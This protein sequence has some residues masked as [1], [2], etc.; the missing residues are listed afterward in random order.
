MNLGS[1]LKRL[2]C[3]LLA[4]FMVL[5]VVG[6]KE[7]KKKKIKKVIK[8]KVIVQNNDDDDNSNND[9][10]IEEDDDDDDDNVDTWVRPERDLPEVKAV[11]EKYVEP[12]IPEFDY[13]YKSLTLDNDYIVVYSLET[14]S[15]RFEGKNADGS[16]KEITTTANNRVAAKDLLV[17]LKDNY[18]V[19]LKIYSN[20]EYD[21]AVKDGSLTGNEKKIIFGD[22]AGYK[23]KLGENEFAVNVYGDNLVFEGGHFAMI[24]KA[25]KW[26]ESIKVEKDKV[27]TLY[28]KSE[29]FKSTVTLEN[30][31]TYTYVWGDEHDGNGIIDNDKW[32]QGA[33]KEGDDLVS[34]LNDPAFHELKNG[35]LRLTGNRY[36]DESNGDVGYAISGDTATSNSMLF[37]NGYV[38]FRARLPYARGAFPAIWS[39]STT[40]NIEKQVPNWE[41]NDGYGV[42]K[43]RAWNIEFDLFESFS[44][45][46]HMTTTVHKWYNG[47]LSDNTNRVK[48]FKDK[49]SYELWIEIGEGDNMKQVNIFDSL[50]NPWYNAVSSQV[51]FAYSMRHKGYNWKYYFPNKETLNNEYHTYAYLYTS[52]KTAVYIDGEKFLEFD[53]DPAYDFKDIDGD[54]KGDD[55]TAN[56]NGVGFDLWHY[57]LYD[58]MIY[59]PG[60]YPDRAA[61]GTA[62]TNEDLPHNMYVDYVR[63][64]QDLKDPSMG[65]LYPAAQS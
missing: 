56:N 29:D 57:F 49:E 35:R 61:N 2:I 28:G 45:Y 13:E 11:V 33:H 59:S 3:F 5:S 4:I 58:M 36:F 9:I 53:W 41:I 21:A 39:L 1:S 24:E 60:K 25:E 22:A 8:K 51:T 17:Y 63:V 37:R 42:Y 32:I 15:N 10:I 12:V 20:V 40:N 65:L 62:V 31:I 18:N 7:E 34:V 46:D 6:C 52:E 14:W 43:N 55:V 16:G 30:G 38:E 50:Y 54:G 23:T 64:Y 27:A 26:F 48:N 47:K 19:N 44:D